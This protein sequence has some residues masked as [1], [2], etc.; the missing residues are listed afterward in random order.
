MKVVLPQQTRRQ[1]RSFTF[2]IDRLILSGV[3]SIVVGLTETESPASILNIELKLPDSVEANDLYGQFI[4]VD[5][6][7]IEI[8]TNTSTSI[9][10]LQRLAVF[11][12]VPRIETGN[13][14]MPV[15]ILQCLPDYPHF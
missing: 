1:S 2:F 11:Q 3:M 8:W 9:S 7:P 10:T 13:K 12:G 15:L 4:G 6:H 14:S 5:T